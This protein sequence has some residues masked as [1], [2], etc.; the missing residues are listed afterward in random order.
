MSLIKSNRNFKDLQPKKIASLDD[1]KEK[2]SSKLNEVTFDTNLKI[3][4]HSRNKLQALMT[5]GYT[6][7]QKEAIDLLFQVFHDQLDADSKKE[8]DFQIKTLEKRDI[9]LKG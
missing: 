7:S 1:L 9:K 4:N 2:K 8:L 5:L 6:A 3:T